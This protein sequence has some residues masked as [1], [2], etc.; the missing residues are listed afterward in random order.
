MNDMNNAIEIDP[1][2]ELEFMKLQAQCW[3]MQQSLNALVG[4]N[5][6]LRAEIDALKAPQPEE[7]Q[8]L[9]S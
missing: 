7:Q 8:K 9:D 6:R 1:R 2:I 3:R 5:T 4:E